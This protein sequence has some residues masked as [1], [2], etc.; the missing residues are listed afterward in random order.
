NITLDIGPGATLLGSQDVGDY[1]DAHPPFANTQLSNCKKALVYAEGA[2]NVRITGG[3]T[4]NGNARG[5]PAWNGNTIKE[6]LRPM[7]IFTTMS[8]NVT[9]ENV[10][11][12]DAG[13]WALVNME[14]EH[15]IVRHVT[16][17]TDLGPTH[18]GIDVVDGHDVLIDDVTVASGDDSICLKSGSARGL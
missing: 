10:T 11:V 9:V 18:D 3:G 16:V 15:L 5:I 7:A 4:I 14:V 12:K 17:S 1:P 13:T 8:K 2:T 6:G